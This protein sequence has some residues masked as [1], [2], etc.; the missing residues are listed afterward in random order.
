MFEWFRRRKQPYE[1]RQILND[2]IGFAME[3]G[4]NWLKPIQSRLEK[5]YPHLTNEELDTFNQSCQEA[6]FFGHSL[7]YNFAEGENKLMDFEVFTNRILEKHPWFSESKLKRLYS[8]SCYYTYKD[9][10]PLEKIKRD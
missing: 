1:R 5:L 10:G 2:G 9:F 7:V 3:F 6:M 8:Q 4:R